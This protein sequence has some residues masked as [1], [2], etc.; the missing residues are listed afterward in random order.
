MASLQQPVISLS[1]SQFLGKSLKCSSSQQT[2]VTRMPGSLCIRAGA[3]TDILIETAKSI[4]SLGHGI[5]AIDK[6]NATCGKRLASIGLENNET[7]RQSYTQ[8][9]CTAPC[10]DSTSQVLSFLRRLYINRL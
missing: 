4:A 6:S 8:L 7:N 5:L 2:S 10:W 3:Y 9:L 1:S